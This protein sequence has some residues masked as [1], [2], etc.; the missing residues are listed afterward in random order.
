MSSAGGGAA[1]AASAAAQNG[2][3]PGAAAA[4]AAAAAKPMDAAMAPHPST[5]E[6]NVELPL[7][8][9]VT[10]PPGDANGAAPPGSPRSPGSPRLVRRNS[11]RQYSGAAAALRRPGTEVYTWGRGDCGQLGCGAAQDGAAPVAVDALRGRDVVSA[12]LGALHVAAV[13]GELPVVCGGADCMSFHSRLAVLRT[14]LNA[15]AL[16]SRW[17][18]VCV[19]RQR[20]AAVGD[21]PRR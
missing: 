16:R 18:A 5:A 21:A 15:P 10:P 11:S 20:R 2:P 4:A 12:A 9:V 6:L 19:G 7:S 13:T 14:A 17:R 8:P 1:A 3:V